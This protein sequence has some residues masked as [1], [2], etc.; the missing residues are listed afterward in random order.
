MCVQR[1]FL[2]F[3]YENVGHTPLPFAFVYP[4]T[5]TAMPLRIPF[6]VIIIPTMGTIDFPSQ[7]KLEIFRN[8]CSYFWFLINVGYKR[9]ANFCGILCEDTYVFNFCGAAQQHAFR[10]L[11]EHKMWFSVA[12]KTGDWRMRKYKSTFRTHTTPLSRVLQFGI[13]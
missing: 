3:R 4:T 12:P 7:A 8:R 5:W 1:L 9:D 11:G 2:H 10:W 13:C 6:M